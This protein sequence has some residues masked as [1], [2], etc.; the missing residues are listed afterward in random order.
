MCSCLLSQLGSLELDDFWNQVLPL[1]AGPCL[2]P[3]N[4]AQDASFSGEER[5][6]PP[7]KVLEHSRAASLNAWVHV[8]KQQ[9]K[10]D[11]VSLS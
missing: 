3:G 4:A 9:G 2:L 10:R 11:P 7:W 6:T 8:A 5:T 1:S